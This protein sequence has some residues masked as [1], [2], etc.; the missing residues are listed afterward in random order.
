MIQSQMMKKVSSI[1]QEALRPQEAR[2]RVFNLS[3]N[4]EHTRPLDNICLDLRLNALHY[5]YIR[6]NFTT[7]I[8]QLQ[9]LLIQGSCLGENIQ[10]KPRETLE[11]FEMPLKSFH[12]LL[13]SSCIRL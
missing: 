1:L 6:L 11:M 9:K 10:I 2:E 13:L 3:N 12:L 7:L 8:V 4:K 5:L